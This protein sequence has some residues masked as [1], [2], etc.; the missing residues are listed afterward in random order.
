MLK[1]F[2]SDVTTPAVVIEVMS[3]DH[4]VPFEGDGPEAAKAL[5]AAAKNRTNSP[6]ANIFPVFVISNSS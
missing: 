5:P 6:T 2:G 3:P 1:A 4:V